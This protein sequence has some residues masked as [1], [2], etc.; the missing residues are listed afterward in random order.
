M[1]VMAERRVASSCG[2]GPMLIV[3]E[4]VVLHSRSPAFSEAI[5]YDESTTFLV[6]A[7][8]RVLAGFLE[9]QLVVLI[10]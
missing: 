1:I 6:W 3:E 8:H 5:Q 2:K 7:I 4:V 9:H 10:T